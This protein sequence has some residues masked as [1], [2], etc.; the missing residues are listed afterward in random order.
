[1]KMQLA[2]FS[3]I[4]VIFA[5]QGLLVQQASATEFES[6]FIDDA[7]NLA[8]SRALP[9]EYSNGC[10]SNTGKFDQSKCTYEMSKDGKALTGTNE[11]QAAQA[12]RDIGARLPTQEEYKRLIRRFEHVTKGVNVNTPKEKSLY[13]KFLGLVFDPLLEIENVPAYQQLTNRGIAQMNDVFGDMGRGEFWTSSADPN[14]SDLAF[15]LQIKDSQF[16]GPNMVGEAPRYWPR[17]V[18]CIKQLDKKN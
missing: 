7:Y 5:F 8:W 11:S 2:K 1:M 14:Q 13:E 16:D 15:S 3:H 9:G 4:L 10:A 12:C 6:V 17:A 18:R